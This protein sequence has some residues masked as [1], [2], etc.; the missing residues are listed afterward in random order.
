M[1]FE[2]FIWVLPDLPLRSSRRVADPTLERLE[3]ED[4]KSYKPKK[5]RCVSQ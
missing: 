4:Q 5:T 1:Q 2:G 3:K